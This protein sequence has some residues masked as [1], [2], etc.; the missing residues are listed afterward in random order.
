MWSIFSPI[1]RDCHEGADQIEYAANEYSKTFLIIFIFRWFSYS[2]QAKENHV[3]T[4]SR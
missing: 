1:F 2:T 3:L 4:N